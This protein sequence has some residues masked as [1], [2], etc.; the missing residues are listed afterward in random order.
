MAEKD[1]VH[2]VSEGRN[3]SRKPDGGDDQSDGQ[4]PKHNDDK[5]EGRGVAGGG[6]N[7]NR[8]DQ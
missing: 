8:K 7:Q 6:K 2:L 3:E 5:G 4:Q 1:K